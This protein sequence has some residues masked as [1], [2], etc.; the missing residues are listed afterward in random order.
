MDPDLRLEPSVV[1]AMVDTATQRVLTDA[2]T[3]SD[4]DAQAPSGLP[5]W[6]RGHV[7]THLARNAEAL[8]NLLTWAQTGVETPMYPSRAQ[9]DADIER[10]SGRSATELV[11]DLAATSDRFRAAAGTMTDAA[12]SAMVRHGAANRPAPGAW[13]PVLRLTELEIHHTDLA[14]GYEPDHWPSEWVSAYLPDAV[15]ELDDRAGEPLALTAT[16]T[17]ARLGASDGARLVAGPQ[18]ALLAWVTG[19]ADGADLEVTPDGP[20]PELG[21]WR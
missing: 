11:E 21:T 7:L 6:T 17:G 4:A 19:R 9:R 5:D 14:V 18:R 15:L 2:G 8:V 3:L 12:W 16:D 1:L 13:I 10:G 20:L